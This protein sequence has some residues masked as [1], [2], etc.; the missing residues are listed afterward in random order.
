MSQMTMIFFLYWSWLVSSLF[1]IKFQ[2][3]LSS[4]KAFGDLI[5]SIAAMNFT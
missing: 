3:S 4:N 5:A 2:Q 1:F